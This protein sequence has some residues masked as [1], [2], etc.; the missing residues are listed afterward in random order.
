[1]LLYFSSI[2]TEFS[3]WNVL[4]AHFLL[5]VIRSHR[6]YWNYFTFQAVHRAFEWYS[7]KGDDSTAFYLSDLPFFFKGPDLAWC[8]TGVHSLQSRA[9]NPVKWQD[10]SFRWRPLCCALNSLFLRLLSSQ[11][12]F[13]GKYSCGLLIYLFCF[14]FTLDSCA[15]IRCVLLPQTVSQGKLHCF[16][17][18]IETELSEIQVVRNSWLTKIIWSLAKFSKFDKTLVLWS[19]WWQKEV[20]KEHLYLK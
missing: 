9:G 13:K 10:I 3:Y 16:L 20:S 15:C 14:V 7:G 17:L 18:R 12:F 11:H 2:V 6:C 19:L 5:D 8:T 1:M 4:S